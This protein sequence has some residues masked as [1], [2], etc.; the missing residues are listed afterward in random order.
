MLAR[1]LKTDRAKAIMEIV[2]KLPI[3]FPPPEE[4]DAISQVLEERLSVVHEI[5]ALT[6]VNATRSSRLLMQSL[7]ISIKICPIYYYIILF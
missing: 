3:P 4:Q 5:E 2:R 1:E 7:S 6:E